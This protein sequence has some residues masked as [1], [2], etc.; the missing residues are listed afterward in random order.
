MAEDTGASTTTVATPVERVPGRLVRNRA[1]RW[2]LVGALV[3]VLAMAAFLVGSLS[4]WSNPFQQRTVDRSSTPLL[5][6]LQKV[7]QFRAATGTFQVLVDVEHDTDNV[8]SVISG[9]R[10]TLFATGTVDATVDF[11]ALGADRVTPSPDR[12]SVTITLPAPVL[13]PAVVDPTRS[14]V[15]GQQRGLVQRIGDALGDTPTDDHELYALAGQKLNAAAR[16]SDLSSRAQESTQAMLTGLA[17]SLGFTHV[18]VT[19]DAVGR[20]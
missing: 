4:A 6:Q 13:S 11:S 15:V 7:A 14:R 18:V 8:P 1:R 10:T 17:G 9:E 12:R 2:S 19:F 20:S 16:Q 3:V 5:L